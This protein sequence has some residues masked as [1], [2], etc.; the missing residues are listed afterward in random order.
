M[1]TKTCRSGELLPSAD[2]QKVPRE[3][4]SE[5]RRF[6]FFDPSSQEDPSVAKF[7]TVADFQYLL[8]F[9]PS[10]FQFV[11]WLDCR[12]TRLCALNPM[13]SA[14]PLPQTFAISPFIAK[15]F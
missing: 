3:E 8:F 1:P 14:S 11:W 6:E 7:H 12:R 9:E 2:V 10:F 4:A 13:Q 15:R 5:K